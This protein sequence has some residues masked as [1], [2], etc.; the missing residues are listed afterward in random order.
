A[1]SQAKITAINI[2]A[3]SDKS[4]QINTRSEGD[5]SRFGV[6]YYID[7]YTGQILGTTQEKNGVSVFMGYMFS[8]HRWLLLDKI[9]EPIIGDLPNRKLGSY[10]SGGMT[11]LFTIGLLTGIVI[12]FPQKIKNWRQGLTIKFDSNWKRINH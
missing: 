2:P 10:I 12:W 9:E 3:D 8:L 4:Y 7:P 1:K 11:I 6:G 5:K